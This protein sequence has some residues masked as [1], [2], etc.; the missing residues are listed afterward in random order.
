MIKALLE[1]ARLIKPLVPSLPLASK[2]VK[3]VM[4]YHDVKLAHP[5]DSLLVLLLL[6]GNLFYKRKKYFY[7]NFFY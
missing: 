7:D 3:D 4:T 5:E 6:F 2:K 1:F